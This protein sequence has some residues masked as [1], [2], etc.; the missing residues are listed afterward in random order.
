MPKAHGH[1]PRPPNPF[2]LF[3]TDFLKK[4][5][6]DPGVDHV[7]IS[8]AAGRAW[9]A[10]PAEEKR[11]WA[12]E[13]QLRKDAHQRMYPDYKFRPDWSKRRTS[14][15]KEARERV[16]RR[17][18]SSYS[19][20]LQL[21]TSPVSPW[22]S[23]PAVPNDEAFCLPPLPYSY[24]TGQQSTILEPVCTSLDTTISADNH[25]LVESYHPI[26]LSSFFDMFDIPLYDEVDHTLDGPSHTSPVIYD[27]SPRCTT[28]FSPTSVEFPPR[29]SKRRTSSPSEDKL[30]V[31]LRPSMEQQMYRD[32]YAAE[33]LSL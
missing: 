3:R 8:K 5:S 16:R 20:S 12:E 26:A 32:D 9:N 31:A 33:I 6:S 21:T 15:R 27:L 29:I 23:S 14:K 28:N 17:S 11:H 25:F 18:F 24:I 4:L 1:I 13:A 19:P 30:H 10:L 22:R 2:I 7:E